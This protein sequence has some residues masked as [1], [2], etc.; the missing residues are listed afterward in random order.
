MRITT[1]IIATGV[2]AAVGVGATFFTK[3]QYNTAL[4]NQIAITKSHYADMGL[5]VSRDVTQSDWFGFTD[6]ITVTAD[7]ELLP[8]LGL[9][10][11]VDGAVRV[12][13]TGD[14][15]IL[16]LYVTCEHRFD[17]GENLSEGIVSALQQ[18]D[19]SF[20]SS[21]NALAGEL[22]QTLVTS[23][24][25]LNNQQ[26]KITFRPLSLTSESNLSLSELEVEG[27]W[28][29]LSLEDSPAGAQVT[30]DQVN[31]KTD[32]ERLAGM[33][34]LG[35]ARLTIEKLA[36]GTSAQSQVSEVEGITLKTVTSEL[37][38]ET[39]AISY[40]V[41]ANSVATVQ[42]GIPLRLTDFRTDMA[43]SGMSQQGLKYFMGVS[44]SGMTQSAA[45]SDA[46]LAEIG[47]N[48]LTLAINQI[49]VKYNDIPFSANGKFILAPFDEATLEA[50]TLTSKLSGKLAILLGGA[51]PE[52]LPQLAP[53][54]RQYQQMG[55]VETTSEGDFTTTLTIADR[56][57]SANGII[58]TTL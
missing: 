5:N 7:S 27:T 24:V 2:F 36:V 49:A 6:V 42:G 4:A 45:D 23:E 12:S 34:Y 14:C 19:Y 50:G 43:V 3:N 46:M 54:L 11:E 40:G 52:Q 56:Q 13:M 9:N 20:R 44:E 17:K 26:G 41:E 35:E 18:V 21:V 51:A 8:V 28:G 39:F 57:L 55:V 53:M 33:L 16:P 25:V 32:M 47:K 15:Q 48:Q 29:G 58:I 1:L 37:D 22:Q 31:I 30:L 38:N 10:E